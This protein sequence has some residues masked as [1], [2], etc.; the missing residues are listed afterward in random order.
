M[1]EHP[2]GKQRTDRSDRG[3]L[4]RSSTDEVTHNG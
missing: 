4:R 2:T 1:A 3:A